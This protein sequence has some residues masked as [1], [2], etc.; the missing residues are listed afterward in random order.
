[1]VASSLSL[2]LLVAVAS[3]ERRNSSCVCAT[4]SGE[5]LSSSKHLPHTTAIALPIHRSKG[6][7]ED[8]GGDGVEDGC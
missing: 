5:R 7:N 3:G 8:D 6:V 4:S 1:M 2:S